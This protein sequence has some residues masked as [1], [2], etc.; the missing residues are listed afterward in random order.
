MLPGE[1]ERVTA[2]LCTLGMS[3]ENIRHVPRKY[4]RRY[5]RQE[6]HG[7]EDYVATLEHIVKHRTRKRAIYATVTPGTSSV[8]GRAISVQLAQ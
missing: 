7:V 8:C 6:R 4:W 3:E 2:H 1:R 5:C